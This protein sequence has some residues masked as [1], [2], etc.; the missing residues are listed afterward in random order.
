VAEVVDVVILHEFPVP[1]FIEDVQLLELAWEIKLLVHDIGSN[2]SVSSEHFTKL[3]SQ[4]HADLTLA[5]CYNN[6]RFF[7]WLVFDLLDVPG[8][9]A[10]GGVVY[11]WRVDSLHWQI[12]FI[13]YKT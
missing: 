8:E 4:W 9:G 7:P 12:Y 5:A 6:L 10:V 11:T 2:D 3:P 13:L 1:R